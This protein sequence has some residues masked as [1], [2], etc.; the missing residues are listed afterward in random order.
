M[1]HFYA[2]IPALDHEV[3]KYCGYVHP[4]NKDHHRK[5]FEAFG[6]AGLP[7]QGEP[8]PY[9]VVSFD[10][11]K[12]DRITEDGTHYGEQN[13]I[14]KQIILTRREDAD[15]IFRMVWAYQSSPKDEQAARE[16]ANKCPEDGW[17][18][19]FVR[20]GDENAWDT[21][22]ARHEEIE[23]GQKELDSRLS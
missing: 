4:L 16:Y 23:A 10:E 19:H 13:Y 12:G 18:V 6:T 7:N 5:M 1:P 9:K 3:F 15:N 22:I 20:V 8:G 17:L 11:Y 2:S 21:C 14:S